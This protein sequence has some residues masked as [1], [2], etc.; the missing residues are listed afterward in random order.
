[1]GSTVAAAVPAGV[2]VGACDGAA[3][4]DGV[5]PPVQAATMSPTA[6]TAG[7]QRTID[8]M[9]CSGLLDASGERGPGPLH[10]PGTGTDACGW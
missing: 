8:D 6:R 9:L 4:G 5:P 1:V 3:D 2:G 10:H 7:R